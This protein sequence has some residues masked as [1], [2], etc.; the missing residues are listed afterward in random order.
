MHTLARGAYIALLCVALFAIAT[1][2][3]TPTITSLEPNSGAPGIEILVRGSNLEGLLFR[4]M[5]Y[6]TCSEGQPGTEGALIKYTDN[7]LSVRVPKGKGTAQVHVVVDHRHSNYAVFTYREPTI[8]RIDP[9][10][11]VPGETV[12]IV[13]KDFG[14]KYGA[15][16]GTRDKTPSVMSRVN[17]RST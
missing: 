3:S 2:A 14:F 5:V 10:S 8:H 7:E 4:P 15:Q 16:N 9:P 13:G 12:T 6:F 11:G 17:C 1:Y